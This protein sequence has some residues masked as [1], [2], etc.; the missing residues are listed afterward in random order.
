MHD[1]E[2]VVEIDKFNYV[3]V[4][5]GVDYLAKVRSNLGL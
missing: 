2:T 1:G 4:I 5:D 3:C